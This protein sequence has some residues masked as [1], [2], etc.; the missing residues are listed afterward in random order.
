MPVCSAAKIVLLHSRWVVKH[1]CL[2]VWS[3][4]SLLPWFPTERIAR[5]NGHI[6]VVAL[7]GDAGQAQ[8]FAR[9]ASPALSDGDNTRSVPVL[10]RRTLEHVQDPTGSPRHDAVQASYVLGRPD[11]GG[12]PLRFEKVAVGGTFDRLHA[13][14]RLLLAATAL[15]TAGPVFIGV[16]GERLMQDTCRDMGAGCRV[17]SGQTIIVE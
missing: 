7:P 15:V 1:V 9:S 11:W 3:V 6:S 14:H 4:L 12:A 16:T 13:G 17:P 10:D 2:L 5:A 8:A